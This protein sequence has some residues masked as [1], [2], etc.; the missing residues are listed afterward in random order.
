[1]ASYSSLL[2][3]SPQLPVL[4]AFAPAV[5]AQHTDMER[6]LERA[7]SVLNPTIRITLI[8]E[9]THPEVVRSFGVTSLPAFIL[10][11]QGQELWRYA[12]PIDSSELVYQ[13]ENQMEEVFLK[14]R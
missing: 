2:T 7:R 1:M 3:A 12:G 9:T 14:T 5:P 8:S 6:F 13:L 10:L 4:L 11:Q